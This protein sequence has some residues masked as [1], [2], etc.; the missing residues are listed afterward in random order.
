MSLSPRN[1]SQ[2]AVCDVFW[3]GAWQRPARL[4]EWTVASIN[5]NIHKTHLPVPSTTIIR[6]VD[7]SPGR[8]NKRRRSQSPTISWPNQRF[9]T[10]DGCQSTAMS[11]TVGQHDSCLVIKASLTLLLLRV[12]LNGAFPHK[13]LHRRKCVPAAITHAVVLWMGRLSFPCSFE[14]G[15]LVH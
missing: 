9:G 8:F 1:G 13:I 2:G 6:F 15:L 4:H 3:P 10:S 7:A 14:H 11:S 12:L 5:M